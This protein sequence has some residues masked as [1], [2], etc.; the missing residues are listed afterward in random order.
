VQPAQR[1]AELIRRQGDACA[2]LGSPLYAGLMAYAAVDALDGGP[3]AVA[4]AGH[5]LDPGDYAVTLRLFGAVHG[6]VLS[7]RAPD[8]AA[9]Y[10]S[11]GGTADPHAAWPQFRRVCA[12]QLDAI[13]PWLESPPQ[14]N[15]IG[16]SA[17]L[18]G[19][20]L[21]VTAATRLP[22]RLRELG[23]SAGLNLRP[24]LLR[25]TWDAPVP[26]SYGPDSSPVVLAHAWTGALPPVGVSLSVVDR[27]GCDLDPVVATTPEGRLRL[28]AYIWPD[29]VARMERLRGALELARQ[30]PAT[31]VR[32]DAVSFLENLSP[33]IGS[34][35]V[36]W[37]SVVWQYLPDDARVRAQAEL[38][39]LGGEATRSSPVAHLSLELDPGADDA[40]VA[41]QLW[42]A[43]AFPAYAD[44]TPI[45]AAAPHGIPVRWLG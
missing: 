18:L 42:P 25:L 32:A 8:L 3:V 4:L 26:G 13:R 20:L 40:N 11:V 24:D 2:R 33:E 27:G 39:R 41:L 15:E 6:L 28:Q 31:V 36:I 34:T 43:S 19:G 1:L 16:R 45:G 7:G 38:D 37:H 9:Y 12:E 10:P 35:L 22:V 21:Y 14:T 44:A 29:Q 30:V 5:E 23:A 17:A